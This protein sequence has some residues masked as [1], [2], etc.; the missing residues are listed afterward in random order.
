MIYISALIVMALVSLSVTVIVLLCHSEHTRGDNDSSSYTNLMTVILPCILCIG[1]VALSPSGVAL[2]C[3]GDVLNLTCAT[4]GRFLEWSF[5]LTPENQTA[6]M[7][8]TRTLQLGGPNH[9]Q[10]FEQI[11][12]SITFIYSR[13]SAENV[14]PVMSM[15]SINPVKDRL[16][17][18]MINCTDITT[19]HLESTIINVVNENEIM[20]KYV[21]FHG[22]YI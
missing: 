17:G 19:S 2:V 21:Y 15:L 7:R 5:S 22:I 13:I 4:D 3:S 11:I 18:V 9:L 16:N 6:P 8:Y 20:S 1:A 12:G 14:L 10:T